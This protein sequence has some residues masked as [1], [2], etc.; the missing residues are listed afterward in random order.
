MSDHSFSRD[1]ARGVFAIFY[2]VLALVWSAYVVTLS[3]PGNPFVRPIYEAGH[4]REKTIEVTRETI[5]E[6]RKAAQTLA[7]LPDDPLTPKLTA[8]ALAQLQAQLIIAETLAASAPPVD[9]SASASAAQLLQKRRLLLEVIRSLEAQNDRL[10]QQ[11]KLSAGDQGLR[12]TIEELRKATRTLAVMKAGTPS[13]GPAPGELVHLHAQLLF[14]ATLDPEKTP[15]AAPCKTAAPLAFIEHSYAQLVNAI[16]RLEAQLVDPDARRRLTET[17]EASE[18][19]L[20]QLRQAAQTLATLPPIRRLP[21]S[22]SPDSPNFWINS[23]RAIPS[24]RR[25]A[26]QGARP[27]R[28]RG[29][30]STKNAPGCSASSETSN[31]ASPCWRKRSRRPASGCCSGPATSHRPC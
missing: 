28:G 1:R 5:A 12:D 8:A 6:L 25:R 26:P 31:N 3:W 11:L 23:A 17:L 2:L 30:K 10:R 7:A 14:A 16:R 20:A 9:S 18:R 15:D 4:R 24:A 29:N 22:P 13:I 19:T 27:R 21:P